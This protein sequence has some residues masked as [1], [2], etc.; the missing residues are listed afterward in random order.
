MRLKTWGLVWF[1]MLTVLSLTLANDQ[2]QNR[3]AAQK[4]VQSLQYQHGV[5]HLPGGVA[6]LNLP[7]G[8]SYLSPNDAAT[9]LVKLWGNPPAATRTLGM[10]IPAG[11]TPAQPDCWAVTITST[12]DGYVKDDDA[13]EINYDDLLKQMQVGTL[14]QNKTRTARGYPAIDLMGW[15]EPPHYDATSHKLYWAREFRVEGVSENMLNFEI[16]ILGRRGVLVLS[17]IGG[18]NQL[19]EIRKQSPEILKLV[20]FNHGNRY[21]DFDPK[22]DRM[23]PYGLATLV[24]GGIAA[25]ASFFQLLLIGLRAAPKLIIIGVLIFIII[26]VVFVSVWAGSLSRKRYEPTA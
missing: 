15:A 21:A 14:A 25:K 13:S 16:R 26:A 19:P 10:L 3:E 1:G 6:S 8:I 7:A 17:T 4:L 5:I 12:A 2:P 11:K 20:E 23:A 22:T 24:S 9:V 18:M